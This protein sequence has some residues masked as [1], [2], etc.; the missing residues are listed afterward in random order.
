MDHLAA[1][2]TG[3]KRL[4]RQYR[5]VTGLFYVISNMT[6]SKVIQ[7]YISVNLAVSIAKYS[8]TFPAKKTQNDIKQSKTIN[9][10]LDQVKNSGHNV[11]FHRS[12]IIRKVIPVTG[13]EIV[14]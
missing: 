10:C 6:T 2:G 9:Y 3:N 7:K 13:K 5:K 4:L 11:K 14:F 1:H 8:I 12:I